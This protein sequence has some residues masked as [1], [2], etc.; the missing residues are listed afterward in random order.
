MEA[1]LEFAQG[2]LFRFAMAV[3]IL[4]IGRHV[5]LSVAGF[6]EARRRASKKSVDLGELASRTI[7]QANP[8]RYLV[9]TRRLYTL[10]TM[11]MH[12]GV[13]VVPVFLAGH[14]V[15]WEK[16]LGFGWPHIPMVVA[17][18]LTLVTIGALA[19]VIVARIWNQASRSISRL[20][21]WVL[22]PLIALIFT[23]G[24]LIAHPYLDFMPYPATRLVH[25]LA[26]D[27]V[28]ML[29]PFT[30]LA[31][32]I[33]LPFSQLAVEMGWRFVPGAGRNVQRTL[34]KEGQ[35]I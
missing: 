12:A 10:L 26:G 8:L 4:G 17:D 22:P 23:S 25:V 1:T 30:K 6:V 31:H 32:M 9:R 11:T 29:V 18:W 35:P 13:L 20:Q 21:D 34:G 7:L 16:G 2:P 19:A 3:A 28:L 24:Y 27:L 14:I 5:V 15:L 33:L